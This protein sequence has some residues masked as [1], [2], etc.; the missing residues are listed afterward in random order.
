MVTGI[1]F[2]PTKVSDSLQ[3]GRIKV[4]KMK[5]IYNATK[6]YLFQINAVF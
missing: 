5:D 4:K 6:Y 3:Q 2:A 1:C